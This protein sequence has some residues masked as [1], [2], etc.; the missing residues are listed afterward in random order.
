MNDDRLGIVF[1]L[2]GMSLFSVQDILVR[3][4]S[5]VGSLI[6]IMTVRGIFGGV[7]LIGFLKFTGRIVSI[8]SVYPKLAVIRLFIFFRVFM[9]L[10]C[11]E[12]DGTSGSHKSVLL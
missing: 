1:I 9:F 6:Q 10:F 4:L 5:D 8:K 2:I 7:I 11:L 12:R 3:S